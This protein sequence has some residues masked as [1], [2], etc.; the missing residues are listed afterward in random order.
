MADELKRDKIERLA[1]E[2]PFLTIEKIANLAN[3][4]TRYVRTVL[5]EKRISLQELRR[6]Y[7]N[8]WKTKSNSSPNLD[9]INNILAPIA[10]DTIKSVDLVHIAS[11][12]TNIV[13]EGLFV[14]SK[15]ISYEVNQSYQTLQS[16]SQ[17]IKI[18]R[19]WV[20]VINNLYLVKWQFYNVTKEKQ[21]LF[22][23]LGLG[24]EVRI[25]NSPQGLQFESK[26]IYNDSQKGRTEKD[27]LYKE[28]KVISDR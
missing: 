19:E 5:Y 25:V 24:E 27:S 11:N 2:D 26:F 10:R 14:T 28:R 13:K 18:S 7:A 17:T 8:S 15:M 20:E 22:Y 3:T 12:H 6:A 4:T 9:D 16:Y 21:L 1:T 23:Y